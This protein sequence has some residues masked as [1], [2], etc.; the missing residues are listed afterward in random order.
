MPCAFAGGMPYLCHR[1]AGT[2]PTLNTSIMNLST[3][4]AEK[5]FTIQTY[6]VTSPTTGDSHIITTDVVIERILNTQGQE[7]QQVTG[8]LQQLDF[9][10]GDFH[11]FFKHLATNG[12]ALSALADIAEYETTKE[13][14]LIFFVLRTSETPLTR[15]ELDARIEDWIK[16]NLHAEVDFHVDK[17]LENLTYLEGRPENFSSLV[18]QDSEQRYWL[19][20]SDELEDALEHL[21]QRS[22]DDA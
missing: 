17:T 9:R 2:L 10:N 20:A 18:N 14:L 6:E 22:L 15:D 21:W 7:R 12:A 13:L 4:F 19:A 8:I 5:D 1:E 11:H 16:Q 3:F